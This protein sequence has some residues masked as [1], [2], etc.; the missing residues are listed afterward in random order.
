MIDQIRGRLRRKESESACVC[1]GT[2]GYD[3]FLCLGLLGEELGDK[4]VDRGGSDVS[5]CRRL[6]GMNTDR[7]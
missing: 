5:T 3:L 1:T 7:H 4:V 6:N 2:E